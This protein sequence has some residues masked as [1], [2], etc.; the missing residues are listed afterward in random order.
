MFIGTGIPFD[1]SLVQLLEVHQNF[2]LVQVL[3][4]TVVYEGL[5]CNLQM[6]AVFV[7]GPCTLTTLQV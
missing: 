6:I 5:Q 1:K 4:Y 3:S 2:M 7:S